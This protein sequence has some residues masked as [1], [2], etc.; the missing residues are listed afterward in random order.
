MLVDWLLILI[1]I[2]LYPVRLAWACCVQLPRVDKALKKW[3]ETGDATYTEYIDLRLECI[4]HF[5]LL[6]FHPM[7]GWRAVDQLPKKYR[8][9]IQPYLGGTKR[10][11]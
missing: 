3:Y 2:I 6:C 7:R 10:C 8:S 5:T 4:D 9:K 11:L 1:A